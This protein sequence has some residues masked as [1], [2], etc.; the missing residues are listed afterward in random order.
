MNRRTSVKKKT[1]SR[2][3]LDVVWQVIVLNDSVNLISYVTMVLRKVFGFDPNKASKH[4]L[5]AHEKGY[6][7]VWAGQREHAEYYA[8]VLQQWQVNSIIKKDA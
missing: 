3:S 7:V 4:T 5:E 2:S 6:S 8:Q 1:I